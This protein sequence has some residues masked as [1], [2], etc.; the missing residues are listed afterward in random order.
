MRADIEEKVLEK[1]ATSDKVSLIIERQ[2]DGKMRVMSGSW[3][4]EKVILRDQALEVRNTDGR[5]HIAD[6][7][8]PLREFAMSA[9]PPKAD[10]GGHRFDVR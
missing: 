2:P 1:L 4:R 9:L 10:I 8:A 7:G 3:G 6:K 5:R